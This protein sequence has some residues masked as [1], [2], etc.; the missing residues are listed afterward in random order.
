MYEYASIR[1]T[2]FRHQISVPSLTSDTQRLK[3]ARRGGGGGLQKAADV[4]QQDARHRQYDTAI[5][6]ANQNSVK[7]IS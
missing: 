6:T 5:V 7:T 2:T 1:Q 3:C 4:C